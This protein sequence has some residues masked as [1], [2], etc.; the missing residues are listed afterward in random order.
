MK[1]I[2]VNLV[3][4]FSAFLFIDTVSAT[5]DNTNIVYFDI[6]N[7]TFTTALNTM[8]SK[9]DEIIDYYENNNP[10]DHKIVI[11]IGND[12]SGAFAQVNL[13]SS[14]FVS[15]TAS[16]GYTFC[17]LLTFK[18]SSSYYYNSGGCY[19][20]TMG[21]KKYIFRSSSS[22]STFKSDMQKQYSSISG[23]SAGSLITQ[24]SSLPAFSFTNNQ[25]D[26]FSANTKF[27]L[28]YYSTENIYNYSLGNM[29]YYGIKIGDT[30]LLFDSTT[31]LEPSNNFLEEPYV[32]KRSIEFSSSISSFDIYVD[33]DDALTDLTYKLN[34]VDYNDY[35]VNDITKAKLYTVMFYGLKNENGLYHWEMLDDCTNWD[36]P[37]EYC[38]VKSK[39]EQL[40]SEL[41]KD[42]YTVEGYIDFLNIFDEYETVRIVVRLDNALA[43]KI[44]YWDKNLEISAVD[45][46][47]NYFGFDY[48]RN[49]SDSD[50]YRYTIF[51][52]K[53][54]DVSSNLY[55]TSES[56]DFSISYFDTKYANFR[57]YS[58]KSSVSKID[59]AY[60]FN[61]ENI[62]LNN[63]L[64]F[65][66]ATERELTER[67]VYQFY[68]KPGLYFS[69]NDSD[70]LDGTI[71][72]D[73]TGNSTNSDIAI[74][75]DELM[76]YE[77]NNI[78]NLFENIKKFNEKINE[79]SQEIHSVIQ[80]AYDSLNIYIKSFLISIF[81]VIL[82]SATVILIRK[83]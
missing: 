81:T 74:D 69:F 4:F 46:D 58:Y 17:A 14:D 35:S 49:L 20:D 1:K 29:L 6:E 39:F 71:Y 36:Y 76:N 8:Q 32:A 11:W 31:H 53:E 33:K 77:Y 18:Y 68:T 61:Y 5:V 70:T 7:S 52:T 2:I 40:E 24:H 10:Y 79:V 65:Y 19:T 26:Y 60:V 73:N 62:G 51:T 28:P 45:V 48:S 57:D 15:N 75:P 80:Y 82:V 23:K 55:I 64:G 50:L 63:N 21:T 3:I 34:Y 83:W 43:G 54:Q 44:D 30:K 42:G 56:K 59:N 47:V 22:I 67:I 72:I 78:D 66:I 9:I 27:I 41:D 13:L 12:S 37:S 38:H 16:D 25:Y